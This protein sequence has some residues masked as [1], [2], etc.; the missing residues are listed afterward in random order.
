MLV[1]PQKPFSLPTWFLKIKQPSSA[2]HVPRQAVTQRR[3]VFVPK[4]K[5]TQACLIIFNYV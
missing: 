4:V 1:S 3:Y 2:N 5:R